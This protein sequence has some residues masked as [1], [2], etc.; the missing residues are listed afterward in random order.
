[1]KV[2]KRALIG[3]GALRE[4]LRMLLTESKDINKT[5]TQSPGDSFTVAGKEALVLLEAI[6]SSIPSGGTGYGQKFEEIITT[7]LNKFYN[8]QASDLNPSEN[9]TETDQ[10]P[11][12]AEFADIIIGT[13]QIE[14]IDA[15]ELKKYPVLSAK[16]NATPKKF[17]GKGEPNKLRQL[18]VNRLLK[19]SATLDNRYESID[20][21]AGAAYVS[22]NIN[23]S[24]K[25]KKLVYDVQ[26]AIPERP[27]IRLANLKSGTDLHPKL[28]TQETAL[29]QVRKYVFGGYKH[30][31]KIKSVFP[32][33]T[34]HHAEWQNLLGLITLLKHSTSVL[35]NR[36]LKPKSDV[37]KN[38]TQFLDKL[39]TLLTKPHS[40]KSWPTSVDNSDVLKVIK[41]SLTS[42]DDIYDKLRIAAADM[43]AQQAAKF[44]PTII[45]RA[46]KRQLNARSNKNYK[47]SKYNKAAML[48]ELKKVYDKSA[49]PSSEAMARALIYF[50]GHANSRE[51][52]S[53]KEVMIAPR[54]DMDL[55]GKYKSAKLKDWIS[56]ADVF[57]I[58]YGKVIS[59]V[60]N[61]KVSNF[62]TFVQELI[63][64]KY[65][66]IY[67]TIIID[68]IAG[69]G[70]IPADLAAA[71]QEYYGSQ[72]SRLFTHFKNVEVD[73]ET[74]TYP[75]GIP[76]YG[77]TYTP[78]DAPPGFT[79]SELD[80]AIESV[81][82]TT[83]TVTTS[84]DRAGLPDSS[85]K[86]NRLLAALTLLSGTDF[87][88]SL[89]RRTDIVMDINKFINENAEDQYN[90][91]EILYS[92]TSAL[93]DFNDSLTM[94]IDSS[95]PRMDV[96]AYVDNTIS[97]I[98]AVLS[99]I[100]GFAEIY[101]SLDDVD[102]PHF[103]PDTEAAIVDRPEARIHEA[104]LTAI[105]S[106]LLLSKY[107]K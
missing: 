61:K 99:E 57:A 11:G 13:A 85:A 92:Y 76:S 36:Y 94:M 88:L 35:P 90:L 14:G 43:L 73:S 12:N 2:D 48:A 77:G 17:V 65:E 6:V 7:I 74:A 4:V 42:L 68:L 15:K 55:S 60:T 82:S 54:V 45:T 5:A 50:V 80:D 107:L 27:N 32:G 69:V 34:K 41:G 49:L 26:I 63:F 102:E 95:A 89:E 105:I 19:G 104:S 25:E 87:E 103:I 8:K 22:L 56:T 86:F 96:I 93:L 79:P 64:T 39:G 37:Y 101:N 38:D 31:T 44:E 59:N 1:M 47:Y 21:K 91:V 72:L 98:V 46:T 29:K 23:Q 81:K 10:T 75:V 53:P 18:T 62:D 97:T 71:L 40:S 58:A 84:L 3:E 66:Y 51:Q 70:K 16:S 83:H 52:R 28:A 30:T 78:G 106:D 100:P 9:S 24:N 33:G 67:F 20:L